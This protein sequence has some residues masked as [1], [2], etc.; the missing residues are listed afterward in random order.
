ML[1]LLFLTS[2]KR[3]W[4]SCASRILLLGPTILLKLPSFTL[5]STISSQLDLLSLTLIVLSLWISTAMLVARQPVLFSPNAK[6]FLLYNIIL[7]I[8]LI[9]AFT[10]HHIISFYIFF[11]A[12]LIPTLLLILGWGYQPERLQAGTYLIIYTVTASLPLLFSL[13][14]LFSN[15]G[16]LSSILP[17]WNAQYRFNIAQLWWPLTILAFLVKTPLFLVHLWLPKAHV[18]AP[19]AGSMVLAGV[20]L[21]LGRYGLLRISSKLFLLTFIQAVPIIIL[22][23]IGGALARFICIRQTDVKSLIAYSSVR[24]IGLATGGIFSATTWGWQGALLILIAHGFCSSC[25][26]SLANISYE[27]TQS[28]SIYITSGFL[29]IFPAITFW[30]FCFSACN[31]AA[32]PSIN[33]AREIFLIAANLSYSIINVLPLSLIAFIAAAYSLLLYTTTQHGNPP[34]L[35]NP[36]QLLNSRNYFIALL[37]FLPLILLITKIDIR[38]SWLWPYSW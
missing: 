4:V 2:T 10:S 27:T 5:I 20:L 28:R 22:C 29:A 35:L 34:K 14:L 33:L 11:E 31:M 7:T 8:I 38:L 23:T 19:V 32:P 6:K 15:I 21:K 3:A 1:L 26:F 12:S 18:E 13:I 36:L 16:H 30:W 24:H 25:M 9:L 37:H 17:L